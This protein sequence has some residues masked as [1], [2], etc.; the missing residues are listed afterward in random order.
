ML[1]SNSG[2]QPLP[3]ADLVDQSPSYYLP[4]CRIG[5]CWFVQQPIQ[6]L[7][8]IVTLLCECG[9]PLAR[10]RHLPLATL[11]LAVRSSPPVLFPVNRR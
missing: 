3:R 10:L 9:P 8:L 6:K 5:R 1:R 2:Q 11:A 7:L 4:R